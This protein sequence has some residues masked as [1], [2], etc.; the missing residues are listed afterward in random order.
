MPPHDPDALS[1][2]LEDALSLPVEARAAF[3][4]DECAGNDALRSELAS[5][6]AAHDAGSEYFEHFTEKIVGPA[7]VVLAEEIADEFSIG[8]TVGQYRLLEKLGA[9][10]MGVVFKALD[11]RL[12]R[13]VAL[14]FLPTHLRTNPQAK[15]RLID[16][17]KVASALDHPNIGVV[18]DIGETSAGRLFIVMAYY[19]GETLERKS[20]RGGLS[21]EEALDVAGQIANAL[22][23][24]HRKKIIHRDVK[25]SN[26][27]LTRDGTAKLLDFGIAKLADSQAATEGATP[28]TL[29]YMSPEQTR[30]S[31]MDHR[32][33][34][35]SLGVVLYEML[36]GATPF[37]ADSDDALISAIR[38]G[39]WRLVAPLTAER[40]EGIVRILAR[41]LAK[42]PE[43]R[44]A[45]AQEL[46]S[47][48]RAL[49]DRPAPAL[50]R[51]P[52]RRA[53]RG[54]WHNSTL[55]A[56]VAVL[57]IVGLYV[58][59]RANDVDTPQHTQASESVRNRLAVLPLVAGSSGE[60][61]Y[62]A[63][64]MTDEL[65]SRLSRIGGL[66]VIARSSVLRYS[67]T[68]KSAN[69]I[70]RELGV[71]MLLR[72]SVRTAASQIQIALQLVDAK[73]QEELW[74]RRYTTTIPALNSVQQSIVL[75][76]AD[77]LRMQVESTDQR[78]LSQLGTTS[79]DAYLLYLRGRH[80]L[81]KRNVEAVRQAKA[82]FEQAL[83]L[84]PSFA[85]AWVGLGDAFSALTSLAALRAADGY[86]RSRAA[87]E[88]A[89]QFEPDLAEA[90][91]CLATAL[92]SYYW[93]F[94]EAARHYRRALD[95]NPNY[96]D[97]HRLYAEYLRFQGRFDEALREARQAEE[98]D[99][100]SSAPQIGAGIVLYWARRY[101]EAIGELRRLL[102]VNPRFSYAYF[103]LALAY[104]QK[105]EYDSA[106]EALSAS[107]AGGA[108]QQETLR[109]YIHA[110][111][112]R[113]SE[114]RQALDRLQVLSRNQDI[115]RWH[116]A[117]IYLGL[118]EHGRAIDL[119]ERAFQARDWQL[120]MLPVEPL[121]DPLR[122]DR[123]FRLLLEQVMQGRREEEPGARHQT[124]A[125]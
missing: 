27:L 68:R 96:A 101:D 39:D 79:T 122:S 20:E 54:L 69:E 121:L 114:A 12:D 41:C 51:V 78:Q 58:P 45:D 17:A 43:G 85:R 64:G 6:L 98:L 118:G 120:R 28:G 19:E 123:R 34:L 103:F 75:H 115:S 13:L 14:K 1:G 22:T 95:L 5:L 3:L 107:G 76:V 62:L 30:G 91:V 87:A 53:G 60:E 2:L 106:L 57:G 31:T 90:H 102:E 16:E 33:D 37:R 125:R 70:G 29:A 73:S 80:Q 10:G 18:H 110:V 81:E 23:A 113:H 50:A 9:G 105:Q 8:Q 47:D 93:D 83:D 72:G 55:A 100:L 97:A 117:I 67:E 36:T 108:L 124:T 32:T 35:W 86:R 116:S 77:A 25:P 48:L 4:D 15:Q 66:R 59:R 92:S 89:L 88:R 56:L 82:H 94:E 40:S 24:A 52:D 42:A 104:I 7:L 119:M 46:L 38:H 74:N 21:V 11:L 71:G 109:G 65:I 61:G 44:Y 63:E 49:D 84:D 111:T 26:I 99:P 112:G